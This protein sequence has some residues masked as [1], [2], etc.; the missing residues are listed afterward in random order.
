[1]PDGDLY[2]CLMT[3]ANATLRAIPCKKNTTFEE[4]LIIT[5]YKNVSRVSGIASIA[6][7]ITGWWLIS[8]IT[9]VGIHCESISWRSMKDCC[10]ML[11]KKEPYYKRQYEI[12]LA[13][14]TNKHL[15]ENLETIAKDRAEMMCKQHI[16]DIKQ[17]EHN[18]DRG[19]ME[20]VENSWATISKSH[21]YVRDF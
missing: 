21:F 11:C 3:K 16:K 9:S 4:N 5:S 15:I 6:L 18:T 13:N 12:I 7:C 20:D 17:Y 14:E 19:S 10:F 1:M 2:L 8:K